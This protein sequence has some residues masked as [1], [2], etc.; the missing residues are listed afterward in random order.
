MPCGFIDGELA[1]IA[2]VAGMNGRADHQG[3]GRCETAA[4]GPRADIAVAAH[5]WLRLPG[6][7]LHIV[8]TLSGEARAEWRCREY[9]RGQQG[10]QCNKLTHTNSSHYRAPPS[11]LK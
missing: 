6:R 4:D 11:V 2:R 5:R 9:N 1:R 7:R 10:H 3:S 8:P